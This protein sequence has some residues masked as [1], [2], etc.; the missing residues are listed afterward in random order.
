MT[1]ANIPNDLTKIANNFKALSSANSNNNKSNLALM[2]TQAE[3][4]KQLS[5]LYQARGKIDGNFLNYTLN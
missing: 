1:D 2:K 4:K 3:L 5:N